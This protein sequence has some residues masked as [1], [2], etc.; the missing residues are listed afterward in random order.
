MP[1]PEETL[2]EGQILEVASW[3]LVETTITLES[4]TGSRHTIVSGEGG[5][6]STTLAPGAW[7]VVE[8]NEDFEPVSQSTLFVPAGGAMK[9]ALLFLRSVSWLEGAVVD[10]EHH[11][12]EKAR[13]DEVLTDQHGRFR[14][15][16]DL[17]RL[18]VSHPCCQP[19]FDVSFEDAGTTLLLRRWVPAPIG[20][21][22]GQVVDTEGVPCEALVTLHT[23]ADGGFIQPGLETTR[24]GTF[25]LPLF[26]RSA[27]VVAFVGHSA[28][29]SDE[30]HDGDF[31]RLVVDCHG[32]NRLTLVTGRVV[33]E[34]GEPWT[35]CSMVVGD[36]EPAWFSSGDGSFSLRVPRGRTQLG[37]S[38]IGNTETFSTVMDLEESAAQLDDLVMPRSKRRIDGVVFDRQTGRR[39]ADAEVVGSTVS[40]VTDEHGAFTLS[41]STQRRELRVSADGYLPYDVQLPKGATALTIELTREPSD[42]GVSSEYEGVGIQWNTDGP[43]LRVLRLHPTGPAMEA[44]AREDD[45]L[46]AVDGEPVGKLSLEDLLARMKGPAGTWVKLSIRRGEGVIDLTMQRRRLAW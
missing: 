28:V 27:R 29:P 21:I 8:T 32:R 26:T 36:G 4:E 17:E 6:F 37:F 10:D 46:L 16:G 44:G 18:R 11:P 23:P 13:V 45:E 9:E 19:G 33:D 22:S 38:C 14:V 40:A 42:G 1:V 30:L 25:V 43:R 35:S 7:R 24:Q 39:I 41:V 12:L 2:V 15:R 5:V 34:H 20:Q 3:A 31:A